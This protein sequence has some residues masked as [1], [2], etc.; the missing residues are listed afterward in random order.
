MPPITDRFIAGGVDTAASPV[1]DELIAGNAAL[2]V[3]RKGILVSGQNLK[4]GALLGVIT[5]SGKLTLSLSASSDGSQTPVSVLAHDTDAS[6]GDAETL[7]YERGDFNQAAITF[8]TG[9]TADSVRAGLRTLGITL[10]KPYG[11]A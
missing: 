5:A 11:V 3:S 6:A 7:F 10:I 9:H 8:G 1:H 2:L 4:R